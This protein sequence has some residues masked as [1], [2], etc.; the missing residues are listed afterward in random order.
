[1]NNTETTPFPIGSKIKRIASDYTGGRIGTVIEING[2]RRRIVW[3]AGH[4]RTWINIKALERIA[5]PKSFIIRGE[6]KPVNMRKVSAIRRCENTS[7]G[8][9]WSE[10]QKR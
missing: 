8:E 4:P 1:M 7:T 3:D 5:S 6:W 9:E 10:Y 2:G